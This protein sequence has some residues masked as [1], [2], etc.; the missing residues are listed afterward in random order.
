[1]NWRKK[2][3]YLVQETGI[4]RVASIIA[5]ITTVATT[6]ASVTAISST[7]TTVEGGVETVRASSVVAG[8]VETTYKCRVIEIE[9]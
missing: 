7:V 1:M 8:S 9:N 4:R 2:L 3:P 6:I 5:T